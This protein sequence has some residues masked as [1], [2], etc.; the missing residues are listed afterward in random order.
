MLYPFTLRDTLLR[1]AERDLYQPYWSNQILDEATRNLVKDGY[2]SQANAKRLMKVMNKA[3]PAATVADYAALE[4]GMRND[5]K[6]RHVAAAAIKAGA[7]VIVS[8]NVKDFGDLP[9]GFEVQTPDEFLCHLYDLDPGLMV[10]IIRAQ[11]AD[12]ENPPR[13]P[14]EVATALAKVAAKFGKT[15]LA[16]LAKA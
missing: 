11:A 2:M 14:Q 5:P 1:C 12:L 8:A 9:D 3:F 13:T 16:D 6:D 15:V 4:A 10:E 7:R